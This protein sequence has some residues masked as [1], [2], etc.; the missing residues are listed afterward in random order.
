MK[1]TIVFALAVLA[2]LAGTALA[3]TSAPSTTAYHF[4]SHPMISGTVI[5]V[6]DR[7]IVV[8]TDQGEQVPLEVD[9]R[10]MAPR[11]LEPGMVMRAEFLALEDCRFYAQRIM[12][13][14]GGMSTDRLQAYANTKDSP[15]AVARSTG[16]GDYTEW[17]N[18]RVAGVGV[19]AAPQT[20][21]EHSPGR[22]MTAV[23][24][25]ADYLFSTGPMV[26]GTVVSVNDHR[27]VVET[28]QGQVVGLVMDSRTMVSG[29]V[30][31]GTVFRAEFSE[32]QDGRFYAKRVTRVETS[33][34]DR[35]Q[36]YAHTRDSDVMLAS[37][38]S[39]C[40]FEKSA[41]EN[42]QTSS[43]ERR[44]T[45][46][47]PEPVA[48]VPV[49]V[50]AAPAPVVEKPLTLPQTASNQPLIALI[51]CLALVAGVGLVVGRRLFSA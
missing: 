13:I 50:D 33:R 32:L 10:T 25:T 37:N 19:W 5:A 26:S 46:V 31:P 38:S 39:D 12:P 48:V 30:A 43:M 40:G 42:T 23:H 28:V 7:Q 22:S 2:P 27:L 8:A 49:A 15:E 17:H 11:D 18:A 24:N 51:G 34:V 41:A 44:E 14:R 6:N 47:T 3:E 4:S 20:M 1:A 45:V 29:D 36:A 16:S 35:E 9:S 21:T